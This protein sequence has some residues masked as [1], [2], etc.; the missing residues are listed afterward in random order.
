MLEQYQN[1][2]PDDMNLFF[3]TDDVEDIVKIINNFY[4]EDQSGELSPNYEL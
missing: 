3:L 2:N 4:G 1:V